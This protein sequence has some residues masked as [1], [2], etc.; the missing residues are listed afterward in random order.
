MLLRGKPDQSHH[1]AS[2]RKGERCRAVYCCVSHRTPCLICNQ[3]PDGVTQ[4]HGVTKDFMYFKTPVCVKHLGMV[5]KEQRK[6][7]PLVYP[8]LKSGAPSPMSL[9]SCLL[10]RLLERVTRSFSEVPRYTRR[11]SALHQ[12]SEGGF[13]KCHRVLGGFQSSVTELCGVYHH[14]SLR[15]V[16]PAATAKVSPGLMEGQSHCLSPG[17]G[18]TSVPAPNHWQIPAHPAPNGGRT[19]RAGLPEGALAAQPDAWQHLEQTW[20]LTLPIHDCHQVEV[21]CPH[22]FRSLLRVKHGP[23]RRGWLPGRQKAA[24]LR[25][26]GG[27]VPGHSP[28]VGE[29]QWEENQS[30]NQSQEEIS[31]SAGPKH[32]SL[33]PIHLGP[34]GTAARCPSTRFVSGTRCTAVGWEVSPPWP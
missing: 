30:H 23:V 5:P 20:P 6:N 33:V 8:L 24:R 34:I 25:R 15:T 2:S 22:A 7:F 1:R 31:P 10:S 21:A 27:L 12:S 16:R 14:P 3:D 28:T 26:S 4:R 19:P 17:L 29:V 32:P 9:R 18:V 11:D 13:S